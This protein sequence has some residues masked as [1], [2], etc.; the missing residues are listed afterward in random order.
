MEHTPFLYIDE[1][2][3]DDDADFLRT[4]H[5]VVNHNADS[6]VRHAIRDIVILYT[7]MRLSRILMLH[8]TDCGVM[9]LNDEELKEWVK[10]T[11]GSVKGLKARSDLDRLTRSILN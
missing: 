5:D 9:P 7:V 4:L 2:E 11:T 8:H 10:W 1:C 3:H 6:N